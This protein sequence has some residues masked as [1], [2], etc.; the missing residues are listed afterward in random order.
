MVNMIW[1]NVGDEVIYKGEH[2]RVTDILFDNCIVCYELSNGVVAYANELIG[3]K[4][5]DH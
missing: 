4:H 5:Y 1:F 2:Y 3:Y